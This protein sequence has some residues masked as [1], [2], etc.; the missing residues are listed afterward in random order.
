MNDDNQKW[1]IEGVGGGFY[2]VMSK[3]T[4]TNGGNEVIEVDSRAPD[5]GLVNQ[6]PLQMWRFFAYHH[7]EWQFIPVQ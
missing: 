7:Q 3:A 4:S 5:D 1:Q 2:Q 6:D